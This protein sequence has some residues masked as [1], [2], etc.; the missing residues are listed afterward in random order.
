MASS[1]SGGKKKRAWRPPKA[2]ETEET[3]APIPATGDVTEI[4]GSLKEGVS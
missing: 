1:K 4:D 2:P 3:Q